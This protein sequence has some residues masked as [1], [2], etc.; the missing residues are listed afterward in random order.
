MTLYRRVAT[1]EGLTAEEMEQL[2]IMR[3]PIDREKEARTRSEFRALLENFGE[4]KHLL[5]FDLIECSC[6][7]YLNGGAL[8]GRLNLRPVCQD[9][10]IEELVRQQIEQQE[11]QVRKF[12]IDPKV[13]ATAARWHIWAKHVMMD[14]LAGKVHK[15]G[16]D[17][18]R[19]SRDSPFGQT[20]VHYAQ[21]KPSPCEH[22]HLV[23][24]AEHSVSS[25]AQVE[26][27]LASSEFPAAG[28]WSPMPP[29]EESARGWANVLCFLCFGPIA[30][31]AH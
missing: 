11:R 3:A 9:P 13:S 27:N 20:T 12:G 25:H 23:L 4:P 29:L 26:A 2:R 14:R 10:A 16:A 7:C 8:V 21:L 5:V 24:W 15:G 22:W 30:M 28:L 6:V 19:T 1:K 31:I 18:R 17:G